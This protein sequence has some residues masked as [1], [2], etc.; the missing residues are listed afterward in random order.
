MYIWMRRLNSNF[1]H[2]SGNQYIQSARERVPGTPGFEFDHAKGTHHVS[3]GIEITCMCQCIVDTENKNMYARTWIDVCRMYGY[4]SCTPL[5]IHMR[6]R[7]YIYHISTYLRSYAWG[8]ATGTLMAET[9]NGLKWFVLI[10]SRH[11]ASLQQMQEII[12]TNVCVIT[13][14]KYANMQN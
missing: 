1:G 6:S 2:A 9:S 4:I 3:F 11:N 7:I 12:I 13:T 8:V 10:S 14:P 5:C